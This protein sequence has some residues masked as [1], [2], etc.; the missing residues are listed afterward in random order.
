MVHFGSYH[1]GLL[2]TLMCHQYSNYLEI[3]NKYDIKDVS[4]RNTHV[5]INLVFLYEMTIQN[6]RQIE[7]NY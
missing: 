5:I 7:V 6:R 4:S 1:H 3:F 2:Q